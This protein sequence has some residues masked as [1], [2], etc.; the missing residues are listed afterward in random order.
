MVEGCLGDKLVVVVNRISGILN[1]L[2]IEIE[3][4]ILLES[5]GILEVEVQSLKLWS[6]SGADRLDKSS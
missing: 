2:S 6:F 4:A 3:V 5:K 1:F